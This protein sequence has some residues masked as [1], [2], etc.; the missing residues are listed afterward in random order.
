MAKSQQ[1]LL[2][3]AIEKGDLKGLKK[4]LDQGVDLNDTLG[5][6]QL[7]LTVAVSAD[8]EQ[9][10][11]ALLDAGADPRGKNKLGMTALQ[12]VSS[13]EVA[14]LL[15]AAGAD[16]NAVDNYGGNA[17]SSIASNGDAAMVKWLLS[18]GA[19]EGPTD[20]EGDTALHRACLEANPKV[21]AALLEGGVNPNTRNENG[22][23]PLV[24]VAGRKGQASVKIIMLLL[25]AGADPNAQTDDGCF[26]L[27][28]AATESSPAAIEALLAGGATLDSDEGCGE[29]ALAAAV[30]NGKADT[31]AALLKAGANPNARI[32]PTHEDPG[33]RGK[34]VLELAAA[35]R[36]AAI[37]AL[38]KSR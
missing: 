23:T 33:R 14:A 6:G 12:Y 37:R 2:Q 17:L 5:N 3:I 20:S 32:S 31:A 1:Q 30:Y 7:P 16:L 35:S 24:Y 8:N 11:S 19:R 21:V 36:S 34:S 28:V 25:H 9:I 13:P 15:L 27:Y 10:V 38:F 22:A 18:Q 4:I 29:T 26:P